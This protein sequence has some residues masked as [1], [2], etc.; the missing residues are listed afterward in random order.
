M[1]VPIRRVELLLILASL[2]AFSP[3]ATDMYLPALPN[4]REALGA[5]SSEVQ[6][7]VATFFM[8]FRW[9]NCCMGRSPIASGASRRFIGAWVSL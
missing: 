3:L 8:A 2:A 4:V 7:T 9:A 6:A 1:A 5:T